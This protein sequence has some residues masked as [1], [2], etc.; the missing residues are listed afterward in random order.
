MLLEQ[1][2]ISNFIRDNMPP[3]THRVACHLLDGSCFCM[4]AGYYWSEKEQMTYGGI[5]EGATIACMSR[6]AVCSCSLTTV[7]S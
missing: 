2:D 1:T 6:Q 7:P 3:P 5:A 4:A